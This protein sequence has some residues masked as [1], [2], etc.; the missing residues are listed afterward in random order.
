MLAGAVFLAGPGR[1]MLCG[2]L[3]PACL[4]LATIW[5][6]QAWYLNLHGWDIQ[7]L[8]LIAMLAVAFLA[9][10]T[11]LQAPA[12]KRKLA[13]FAL[14]LAIL[15]ILLTALSG[16]FPRHRIRDAINIPAGAMW[17]IAGIVSIVAYR[18]HANIDRQA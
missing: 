3:L 11:A 10:A 13:A 15:A 16:Q 17:A 12:G 9:A 6:F 18:K 7:V 4:M 5:R 14:V 2:L 1:T 8:A